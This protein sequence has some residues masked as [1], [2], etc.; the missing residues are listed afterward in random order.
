[1]TRL[2]SWAAGRGLRFGKVVVALI[3]VTLMLVGAFGYAARAHAASSP[4]LKVY[5]Y[6]SPT[7]QITIWGDGFPAQEKATVAIGGVNAGT[8]FV[9]SLDPI[10][11]SIDHMFTGQITI[12]DTVTPGAQ[13]LAVTG[14]TS[15]VVVRTTIMVRQNWA[16]YGFDATGN[17]NNPY[18]SVISASNVATLVPGWSAN[19][20]YG[21]G[22]VLVNGVMYASASEDLQAFAE[23]T[24]SSV[25]GPYLQN[26][27]ILAVADGLI[28]FG[29]LSG[30][31]EFY[32]D[33]ASTDASAWYYQ[34]ST[35]EYFGA[36]VIAN[37]IAYVGST[38]A[39]MYAFSAGGC[40]SSTCQP[41]WITNLRGSLP[42]GASVGI[43]TPAI[44]AG[45]V[46]TAA[47]YVDASNG[48]HGT[49]AVLNA[50][51]G[52]VLWMAQLAGTAGEL[53][54][55]SGG[56]VYVSTSSGAV[57]V[58]SAAGC[59]QS[60]CTPLWSAT[61]SGF[62]NAAPVVAGS[63]LYVAS[64]DHSLYAFSATGCG[65]AT[66]SPLWTATT[67]G[68]IIS[69]PVVANDVVFLTS[70]DG[71]VYAFNGAGCGQSTCSWL[72]R[73]N[74]GYEWSTTPIVA[75]GVLYFSTNQ[76]LMTFHPSGTTTGA[77]GGSRS[78]GGSILSH[79]PTRGTTLHSMVPHGVIPL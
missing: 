60:T 64:E 73:Y 31:S 43:S 74:T 52:S 18:E 72:W 71:Y 33:Y 40:G 65:A 77:T 46:Y 17:R 26:P 3:A 35:G 44:V 47:S 5:G 24:G 67:G 12:P 45:N 7:S 36:A 16:E 6:I 15:G 27:G 30:Y 58:F 39:N 70:T 48:H 14:Q 37:G 19:V 32:A 68:V 9:H 63:T 22:E 59:G 1:M 56:Y 38:N 79:H 69:T 23:A 75:N 25:W 66:C 13:V 49:L 53:I 42:A 50:S 20:Q 4:T 57:Q 41:L 54:V 62:V 2:S 28:F 51:T 78:P 8:V 55:V 11:G 29:S 10:D 61:T 34:G 21:T 76:A